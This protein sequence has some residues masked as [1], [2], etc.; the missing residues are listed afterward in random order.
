M[1]NPHRTYLFVSYSH[2]DQDWL[3]QI[4]DV[5]AADKRNLRIG[6]WDDGELTPGDAWHQEV[7]QAIDHAKV[8]LLL[9]SP[10]FLASKFI[11]EEEV[12]RILKAVDDGLT[13]LWVPLFGA[14]YGPDAPPTVAPLSELQAVTSVT[15]PL[16]ELSPEPLRE[17][18]LDLCHRVQKLL[19]PAS[20][21]R[22]LPFPSIGNLFKG[23]N[24]DLAQLEV[25]LR[26]SGSAAI[27][28]PQTVTGMGGI[29]KTRLALE[30]AW[31]H[32]DDFTA[33]LFVSANTP[34][35]LTTNF[36]R[37]CEPLDLP[38]YRLGKQDDQYEAVL[39]WLQQNRNWLLILDNVDTTEAVGAVKEM[40]ANLHGGQILITSRI[41]GPKWGN[42]VRQ[43][44]LDVI[45]LEDAVAF[46]VESSEGQRPSRTDDT[47][48]ARALANKLGCL[49][50]ALTHAAAYLRERFQSLEEYRANFEQHFAQVIAWY[51]PEAIE[52][53]PQARE[54]AGRPRRTAESRTVATTFFIS[55]GQLSQMAKTLLRAGSFLAPE[56]IPVAMFETC[57]EETKALLA[58][59]CSETGEALNEQPVGEALSELA[60][61]SLITRGDGTF[62][63]HR[64]EQAI[65][66]SSV[67]GAEINQWAQAAVNLIQRYGPDNPSEPS[68]WPVW[69]VLL[70]HA[71]LLWEIYRER[72]GVTIGVEYPQS[73]AK[74]FQSKGRYTAA[75]RYARQVEEFRR[76][77]SSPEHPDTLS[78]Q[79][80]LASLLERNGEY[81]ESETLYRTVL[82]ARERILGPECADT[83]GTACGLGWVLNR[84]GKW[85]EAE[86]LHRK[87]LEIRERVLG[88]DH[89]DTVSSLNGLGV[90]LLEKGD[91]A[92]A[93]PMLRRNMEWHRRVSGLEHLN[94][95]TALFNLAGVLER[96]GNHEEAASLQRQCA[97]VQERLLGPEHLSTLTSLHDLSMS[98][99][100]QGDKKEAIRLIRRVLDGYRNVLPADHP[101][102][103]VAMQDLACYLGMDGQSEAAET[104]FRETL[105]GYERKLG[106]EHPATLRTVNNF[107]DLL[108]KMGKPEESREFH[109]WFLKAQAARKDVPPLALR[110]MSATYYQLGEYSEAEKLLR[111]VLQLNFEVPS[112]KCHL[113]RLLI[114][115]RRDQEAREEI[116]EAWE[117]RVEGQPYVLPRIL[118]FQLLFVML[119]CAPS[120]LANAESAIPL[121]RLKTVVQDEKSHSEWSMQ[122][123]LDYLKP[124]LAEADYTLLAALVTAFNDRAKLPELEKIQAWREAT[125]LAIE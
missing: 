125:P 36:A 77:H 72:P 17:T 110:K 32:A 115:T 67:P 70:P 95:L 84:R 63:M 59:W 101:W 41:A 3:N 117:H 16:A 58:L 25:R 83:L 98:V 68:S 5:F 88:P 112:N 109:L 31:R 4:R 19:N 8:A 22:N 62:S 91:L 40:V 50:L 74:L 80:D 6:Y 14:F 123:V 93:E 53:D 71:E 122:P 48:Q 21:P 121:R 107:A 52:Y 20:V 78:A 114:M 23:R 2:K 73:L 15:T 26:Q 87:T 86:A 113:A 100:G 18:L 12:P 60:R 45:P 118:W 44:S 66:Q 11:M 42:S 97:E 90:V 24:G 120:A 39:R 13:V 30:Y 89:A 111:E 96:K 10:N 119:E 27:V 38:E 28:Q 35:D 57:L 43:V 47:E 51:D 34:N 64:M 55:F 54:T 49:P 75:I 108:D 65:V 99:H 81:E 33:F 85:A 7:L 46:L 69:D 92:A 104:L 82:E 29:G 79:D 103:L 76:L 9:V 61:Y 124:K 116:A 102:L 105:A 94:T 37:L 56:P 106:P 1:H